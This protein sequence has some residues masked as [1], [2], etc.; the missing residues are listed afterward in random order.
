MSVQRSEP[1]DKPYLQTRAARGS[2]RKFEAAL[3]KVADVPPDANDEL[4]APQ[5]SSRKR[6]RS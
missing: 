6:A 3:A 1:I 2:R 4:P 5:K